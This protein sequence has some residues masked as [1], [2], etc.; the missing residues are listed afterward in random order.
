MDAI[1]RPKSLT[2]LVTE[3]LRARIIAG[4]FELGSQL[5]E[6]RLAKDLQ[7]SRTPVREAVNRL[8]MEGLL[9]VEPQRGSFVFNLD[10]N[11]LAK[12]CDARTCLETTALADAIDAD[13][14]G[15]H[16]A[17]SDCVSRME[18]VRKAGDDSGY[19]ALDTEFHQLFFDF[20]NN[21]FLNDAYQTIAQKMAALRNR[22]GRHPDHMT[23]SFAEHQSITQSVGARDTDEAL[24]TL[25]MHIDRKEGSY[26][27]VA[28]SSPE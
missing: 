7:V 10:P 1:S 12:L 18:T 24:A 20:A 25:R 28:T 13:A 22:L 5:S 15:L 16:K 9:T 4:D 17:L 19:L 2:E 27:N 11:E 21:R 26:W 6:A 23:K 8:E 14:E 3:S